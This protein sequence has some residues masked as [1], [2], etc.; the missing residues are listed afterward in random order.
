MAMAFPFVPRICDFGLAKLLDLEGEEYAVAR[1]GR[2]A[3]VHG[4]RAGRG[5]E[6]GDRSGDRRLRAGGDPL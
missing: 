4:A 3:L 1:R 5:S 2:I 6:G